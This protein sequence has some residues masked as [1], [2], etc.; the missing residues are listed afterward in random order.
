MIFIVLC[1]KISVIFLNVAITQYEFRSAMRETNL[2]SKKTIC[3]R[4]CSSTI[5]KVINSTIVNRSAKNKCGQHRFYNFPFQMS[6]EYVM[7]LKNANEAA[8]MRMIVAP[9]RVE[10]KLH[11]EWVAET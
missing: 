4:W 11:E 8:E 3:K 10:G 2:Q 7:R 9:Q 6:K 1:F 5:A